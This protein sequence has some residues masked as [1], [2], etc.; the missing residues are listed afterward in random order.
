MQLGYGLMGMEND[1]IPNDWIILDIVDP[2][3][4]FSNQENT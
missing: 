3:T 1:G 2:L 4:V